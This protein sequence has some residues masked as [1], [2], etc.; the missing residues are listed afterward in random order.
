M[1]SVP[2]ASSRSL[3]PPEAL[4]RFLRRVLQEHA[5]A[6]DELAPDTVHDLRV[7]LR[8]CRSLAEGLAEMDG[9]RQWRQL[10]KAARRLQNGLAGLRDV[11]VMAGW[12][13]RLGFTGAAAGAG[14]SAVAASLRRDERKARRA[15]RNAVRDFPR[16]RW[17]RWRSS[18]PKRAERFAAGPASFAD[19]ALRRASEAAAL[20]RGWRRNGSRLAA[21]RLRIAVKRF[22]YTVESFLPEQ[23]AAWGRNLRGMQD[24]LGEMHDL[25]VLRARIV[26]LARE[27]SF[28][29][30]TLRAWLRRIEHAR[31][32]R[33]ERYR[34]VVSAKARTAKRGRRAPVLW[35]GW[36]RELYAMAWINPPKSAGAA[37]SAASAVGLPAEKT[38]ALRGTQP[39]PSSAA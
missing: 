35:D 15:A 14:G 39:P 27:D 5:A 38:A 31:Q 13:R 22:R 23:Y 2:V 26:Q 17:K 25:D 32:P 1:H 8:R 16:K 9:D 28:S 24:C 18:L 6:R 10:R 20:E 21:H 36:S 7:A 3:S 37:A 19:L 33:V 4:S 12:V 11:Q 34:K 29:R 30:Q